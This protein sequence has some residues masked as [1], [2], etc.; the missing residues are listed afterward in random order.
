MPALALIADR[1]AGEFFNKASALG[2]IHWSLACIP[3]R[4]F[5]CSG[6]GDPADSAACPVFLPQGAEHVAQLYARD[7]DCRQAAPNSGTFSFT[8]PVG[9]SAL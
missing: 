7:A 1:A 6:I 8:V 4:A 2:S 9:G 5:F 3:L